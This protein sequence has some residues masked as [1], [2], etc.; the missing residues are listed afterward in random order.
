MIFLQSTHTHTHTHT[1]K[2][3]NLFFMIINGT[4]NFVYITIPHFPNSTKPRTSSTTLIFNH[5]YFGTQKIDII[6][7]IIKQ[8]TKHEELKA[9]RIKKKMNAQENYPSAYQ[10]DKQIHLTTLKFET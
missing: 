3:N 7:Q 8:K 5:F 4:V 9:W 10:C 1:P 2:S 6:K